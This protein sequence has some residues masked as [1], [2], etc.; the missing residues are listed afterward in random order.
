MKAQTIH[1]QE[2]TIKE[3]KEKL[4]ENERTLTDSKTMISWLNSQLSNAQK[5]GLS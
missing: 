5:A 2:E 4:Q 1:S 3:M